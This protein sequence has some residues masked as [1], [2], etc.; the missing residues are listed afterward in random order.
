MLKTVLTPFDAVAFSAFGA[1]TT[2]GEIAGFVSG[3]L[4]VWLVVRVNVWNWPVGIANCVFFGLL[5]SGAGLYAD[6]GL[7]VVYLA[8]GVWGWALWGWAPSRRTRPIT[9]TPRRERL[10]AAVVGVVGTALLTWGLAV[11]TDSTVPLLDALTTVL[12]LLATWGQA[13]KRVEAWW[14]WLAADAIYVP[15]YQYKGLTL[16]AIL[17]VG[18]FALCVAGLRAWRRELHATERTTP[19]G[20]PQTAALPS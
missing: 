19:V 4:C 3:A 15:L 17:Y 9:R 10:G 12:S 5:F 14:L 1:P 16:T 11:L 7:Q 8:L 6:A 2:W 18:F 13:R 20:A